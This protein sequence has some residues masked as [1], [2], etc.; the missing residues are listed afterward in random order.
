[1]KLTR[2]LLSAIGLSALPCMGA[3]GAPPADRLRAGGPCE[4]HDYAGT[5]TIVRVEQTE[6]SRRQAKNVGGAGYEGYE[7]WF[8]FEPAS[9]IGEEWARPAA[10]KEHR[11]SLMNS[12]YPGPRYLQKYGIK[13]GLKCSCVLKAIT[14]GT[15]TPIIFDFPEIKRDD[16]FE[17]ARIK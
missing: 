3:N 15:C 10:G 12:W 8:R 7:V 6:T 9:E 4:Y 1:M 5:A 16:Y 14:K 17:S 11:L 2:L 13:P